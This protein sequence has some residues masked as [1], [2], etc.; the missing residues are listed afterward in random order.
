MKVNSS[1]TNVDVSLTIDVISVY[2]SLSDIW[3]EVF[4]N[5]SSKICGTQPL[6]NL[7]RYSLV[8]NNRGDLNK[9]VVRQIT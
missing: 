8:P 6:K 7:N 3:D 1:V 9:R 4:K 2:Q 5:G